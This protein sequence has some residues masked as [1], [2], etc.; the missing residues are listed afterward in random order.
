MSIYTN[1]KPF[2]EEDYKNDS[3]AKKAFKPCFTRLYPF[4]GKENYNI[5]TAIYRSKEDYDK[6]RNPVAWVE[7]EVKLPW[8]DFYCQYHNID[9]LYK[10]LKYTKPN[11]F[12]CCFNKDQTNCCII[13]IQD[14]WNYGKYIEKPCKNLNGKVDRFYRV[15]RHY[16]GWGNNHIE[17]YLIKQLKL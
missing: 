6:K 9:Y 8:E 4:I 1:R 15:P 3:K 14:I 10:K 16:F 13:S 17:D 11:M 12:W 2:N 5:D 7:L